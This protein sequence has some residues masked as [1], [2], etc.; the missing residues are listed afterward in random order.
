MLEGLGEPPCFTLTREMGVGES[1]LQSPLHQLDKC[2]AQEL[3]CKK[4]CADG[5]LLLCL[6]CLHTLRKA[7]LIGVVQAWDSDWGAAEFRPL[8][9]RSPAC[10]CPAPDLEE[11]TQPSKA[12]QAPPLFFEK[13]MSLS[14]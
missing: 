8:S 2:L 13:L 10:L 14:A 11:A 12:G 7:E 4:H 9:S 1:E 6:Q 5:G 3:L